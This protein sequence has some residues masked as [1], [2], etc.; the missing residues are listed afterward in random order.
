MKEI[1]EGRVEQAV[2]ALT[3]A[4][5]TAPAEARV[6]IDERIAM[7]YLAAYRWRDAITYAEANLPAILQ[8]ITREAPEAPPP[9]TPGDHERPL[10][11]MSGGALRNALGVAAPVW[12]ELLGAYGRTGNLDQAARLMVQL[13]TACGTRDEAS[14]WLHRARMMFLALAGRPDA[15]RTLVEPKRARHL[16][17]AARLYWVAVALQH[18]GDREGAGATFQRARSRSR[19][20]PRDLIDEA[21][22]RLPATQKVEPSP[23]ANEI[24]KQIE[25]A[26]LPAPIRVP[27]PQA[28]WAT[29]VLTASLVGV[30]ALIHWL[31]GPSADPGVLVRAGAMVRGRIEDGEWWRLISCIFVH[32]GPVHLAVNAIAIYVL[33]RVCE[34]LFGT[35]RTVAIFGGAGVAGATA[36]FLASPVGVSA[37]ASGAIFGVLGAVFIE[38]TLHRARYRAAWKRGMWKRLVVVTI[39]QA[40][41]G[42]LYPGI[43]QWAHGAGLITGLVVGAVLSPSVKWTRAG[44]WL[45]RAIAVGFA[46]VVVVAAVMVTQ[47]TIAD[48]FSRAERVR[49]ELRDVAVTAPAGWNTN[50]RELFDPDNLVIVRT[51][52]ETV[53]PNETVPVLIAAWLIEAEKDARA[54]GFDRVDATPLKVLT[55]AGWEGS[56][57]I[58]TLEDPMGHTQRWRIV[59]VAKDLGG[60][61]VKV[62][63]FVPDSIAFAAPAVFSGIIASAGPR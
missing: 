41:I 37:G 17:A 32:V 36:S 55:P 46:G 54:R 9:V 42:F 34:D 18:Q 24:I 35:S 26:P 51:G 13:E 60:E 53:K 61:V 8:P 31:A 20:R 1:R 44:L 28:P 22:A 14:M 6:A 63:M 12:I 19:G 52:R 47:T 50:P 16:S 15:V 56:E 58:G 3:A 62:L 43:D 21:I 49:Y 59:A 40:G 39:A 27:R 7:L 2:D 5:N 29:W 30:A 11:V 23:A 57:R 45:G 48:S 10:E 33:G 25:A 4:K 38:L